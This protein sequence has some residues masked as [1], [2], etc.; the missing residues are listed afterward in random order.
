M[1]LKY[2]HHSCL[3]LTLLLMLEVYL[4]LP[5]I[6]F[7]TVSAV[8][9]LPKL[10]PIVGW[11]SILILFDNLKSKVSH[12]NMLWLK[13]LCYGAIC[14]N[15]NQCFVFNLGCAACEGLSSMGFWWYVKAASW[16]RWDLRLWIT[17]LATVL[18][19]S[20]HVYYIFLLYTV[21]LFPRL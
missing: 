12:K 9:L 16:D 4:L 20:W 10:F 2:L 3:S 1:V 13:N 11:P 17:A 21:S 7:I 5:K 18:A 19:F 6:F 15:L 14:V 8:T